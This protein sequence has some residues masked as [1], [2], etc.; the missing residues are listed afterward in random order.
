M[1]QH[2]PIQDGIQGSSSLTFLYQSHYKQT[3][4]QNKHILI[5]QIELKTDGHTDEVH[6]KEKK[7]KIDPS[8]PPTESPNNALYT[9]V[10]TFIIRS[11]W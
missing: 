9:V 5:L 2:P 3:Q 4:K 10:A 11:I 1:D 8:P 6:F 7:K